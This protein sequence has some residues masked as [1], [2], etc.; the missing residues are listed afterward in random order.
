[1]LWFVELKITMAMQANPQNLKPDE[2]FNQN[3]AHLS[4]GINKNLTAFATKIG[5]A[6]KEW[7]TYHE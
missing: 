6:P 1:M 7:W 5:M 3:W 4:V 2:F